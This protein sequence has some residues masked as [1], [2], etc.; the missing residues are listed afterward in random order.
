MFGCPPP[1]GAQQVASPW[2]PA[3]AWE[4]GGMEQWGWEPGHTL[5]LGGF[6][7]C[8]SS[9]QQWVCMR[10]GKGKSSARLP[11]ISGLALCLR[12]STY[13]QEF[14]PKEI[15]EIHRAAS[16]ANSNFQKPECNLLITFGE[17]ITC[18]FNC[19]RE[20]LLEL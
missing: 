1:P 10:L 8:W 15:L 7:L 13:V 20:S 12:V 14:Q 4:G 19:K 9:M 3:G 17:K 5:I 16:G 2:G 18:H 6:L 11:Q